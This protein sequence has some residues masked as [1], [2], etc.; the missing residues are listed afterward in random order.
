MGDVRRWAW[1]I[2]C[3][4]S[5]LIFATSTMLWVRSCFISEDFTH[6]STSARMNWTDFHVELVPG[7]IR[8]VHEWHYDQPARSGFG[9]WYHNRLSPQVVQY[10]HRNRGDQFNVR[11]CGFQLVYCIGADELVGCSLL[12][13]AFPL[14]LFLIFAV[15]PLLWWRKRRKL[16]GRGFPLVEP[17]ANAGSPNA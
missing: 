4:L 7:R 5:L 17:V 10:E 1:N 6:L 8:F 3:A 13:A 15:P 12:I 9:E 2:F 16:G 14:W 11:C